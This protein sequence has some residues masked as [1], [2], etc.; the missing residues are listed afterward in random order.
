MKIKALSHAVVAGA[1]AFSGAALADD[2]GKGFEIAGNVAL[3]TDYRF[4]GISQTDSGPAI[5][6]GFDIEHKSGLYAGVWG[7]N[8]DFAGSDASMELDYYVGFAGEINKDVGYDVGWIWYDYPQGDN[9]NEMLDYYEWYGSISAFGATL[10]MAYSPDYT[11]DI[12]SFTY[13][14]LDYSFGLP[15]DISLDLHYGIN[16]FDDGGGST[17]GDNFFGRG[18]Y[19]D[20]SV[21][22]SKDMWGVNW[23]VTYIDTNVSDTECGNNQDCSS[24][25][26]FTIS[27]SL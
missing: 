7:S 15:E 24:Q 22:L 2:H 6:G 16:R 11:G 20:W 9:N 4:R 3:T 17:D 12:N 14:Y 19:D 8:I 27:K 21:G 26:V 13:T 10:G 1:V 25:Y 18:H 23:A 5:Q